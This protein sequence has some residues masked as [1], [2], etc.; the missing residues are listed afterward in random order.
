MFNPRCPP[1]ANPDADP[2]R[3]CLADLVLPR[4]PQPTAELSGAVGHVIR[5]IGLRQLHRTD[6][7]EASHGWMDGDGW[8]G[9]LG[10]LGV[11]VKM[12][13]VAMR[14]VGIWLNVDVFCEVSSV[15]KCLRVGEA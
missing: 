7:T 13:E 11:G 15:S 14:L 8:G 9:G 4:A 6:G 2:P 1:R 5:D 3:G 10:G 12:Y